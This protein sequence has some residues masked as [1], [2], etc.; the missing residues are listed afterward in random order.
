MG[1][2]GAAVVNEPTSSKERNNIRRGMDIDNM[3]CNNHS[4]Y[5]IKKVQFDAK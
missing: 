2:A 1:D 5:I 3:K 4:F